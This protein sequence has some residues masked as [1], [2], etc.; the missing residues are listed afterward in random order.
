MQ[1]MEQEK[2]PFTNESALKALSDMAQP[3]L[4]RLF[5]D[6]PDHLQTIETERTTKPEWYLNTLFAQ[7]Q[8]AFRGVSAKRLKDAA[9][10]LQFTPLGETEKG[11]KLFGYL[12][13]RADVLEEAPKLTASQIVEMSK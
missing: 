11:K 13:G 7:G 1:V 4:T 3:N 10:I 2:P 8:E 6:H 5:A 9:N 12:Y